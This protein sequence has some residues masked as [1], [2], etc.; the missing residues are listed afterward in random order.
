MERSFQTP[1]GTM[2]LEEENG[3]LI[4]LSWRSGGMSDSPLLL[5][6]EAQ[7]LEYFSGVRREFS[8]PLAPRGTPFQLR[9]WNAL[10]KIPYGETR[11]YAQIADAVGNAKACRAV[12]SAN[13]RNPLLILIPCHRVTGAD[14][15]LTGYS[16]GLDRKH[17][18]LELER[19]NRI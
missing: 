8:L 16:G 10:S 5:R 11:S 9:V 18:L 19:G 12:G 1:L 3:A 17:A 14:G 6:A 13:N 15:A 2:C 7:I 4:S